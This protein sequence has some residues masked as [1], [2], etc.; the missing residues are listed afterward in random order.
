V[1][2]I[3]TISISLSPNT[4][5][6][7]VFLA[8]AVMF[9]PFL[10][11][12]K[13]AISY[14]RDKIFSFFEKRPQ[15]VFLF[16]SGRSALYFLLKNLDLKKGDEILIQAFTCTAV[17]APIISAGLKPVYVDCDD[18]FNLDVKDL[19]KKITP[20]AR[21]V[22]LQHTF[23]I[24]ANIEEIKKIARE[25]NLYLI[26]DLAHSLGGTFKNQKLGTFG[27]FSIL[28]FSR[29]KIISCVY[30][31]ALLVNIKDELL[32][33]RL[34]KAYSEIDYPNYFWIFQQ[35]LHPIVLSF[36]VIPFY[37]I[38][39]KYFLV[40]LQKM[41]LLSKAVNKIEKTGGILPKNFL[42]KLPNALAILLLKQFEKLERFNEHRRKTAK[43]FKEKLEGTSYQILDDWFKTGAVFLRLPVLHPLA[44]KIV[45]ASWKKNILLGDWYQKVVAPNDVNLEKVFYTQGSCPNAERLVKMVLNLPTHIKIREKEIEK[46]L[47]FLEKWK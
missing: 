21:A 43:I 34:K 35:L 29:D 27:D 18:N 31:G 38:G 32:L 17:V 47:K 36:F 1:K 3:K 13:K 15:E 41:R 5:K 20:R 6:D 26:E 46:I 33:E 25:N 4:E 16:N 42:K 22:I 24:P 11:K 7:D 19:K 37:G 23:G 14:L 10:W 9:L 44:Y 30:G 8:L 40:L 2:Q 39:G 45:K 12:G 28:S